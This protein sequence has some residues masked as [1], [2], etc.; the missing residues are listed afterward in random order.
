[1]CYVFNLF[2]AY[3]FLVTIQLTPEII[4]E[5]WCTIIG[6]S[7]IYFFLA[8]FF[9]MNVICIDI[10][11]GFRGF[12]GGPGMRSFEYKRFYYYCLYAWGMS[13]L[14]V[15]LTYFCNT[16]GTV[17]DWWYPAVSKGQ[18]FVRNGLPQLIFFYGPMGIIILTNIIL[19]SLTAY[20]I[21]QVKKDTKMLKH[22]E[23]KRHSEDD[24]QK[25]KLYLK[26][27]LA[28]G[29]NW[30]MEIISWGVNFKEQEIPP[31]IWYLTD[32]C[33]ATYGV[34]IFFI[35]VFK[36][37]IWKQLKRRYYAFTGRQYL[38]HSM[39]TT[40]HTKTTNYS[41]STSTNEQR[42]EENEL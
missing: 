20:R 31:Y 39:A 22:A 21:R 23:S 36:K 16:Q 15:L 2:H 19:F 42:C 33:N 34:F 37:N 30:S 14:I 13:F 1:M 26:L 8:S 9:W 18:C 24:Q 25:F 7:C 17:D 5:P 11:L 40:N 29:V 4:G 41:V 28:M 6:Y 38:A 10:F 3:L 32:F 35:F 12:K 27:L